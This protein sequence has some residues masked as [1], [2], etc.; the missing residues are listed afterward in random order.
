MIYRCP[1]CKQEVSKQL[2]E[3]ITGIWEAKDKL[4]RQLK[5]KEEKLKKSFEKQKKTITYNAQKKY[6]L[7]LKKLEEERKIIE[8]KYTN[9]LTK[10][11]ERIKKN[12]KHKFEQLKN[13]LRKKFQFDLKNKVKNKREELKRKEELMKNRYLQLNKQFISMQKRNKEEIEK[14]D[15]KIQSLQE[16]LNKGQT[17][18]VLGL[19]EEARF[20]K[21]LKDAYPN[22]KIVHHGKKGDI[23]HFIIDKGKEV[24]LIVYEL[25]KVTSGFKK[26]H[27]KQTY[28]AKQQR[29]ADYGI[30]V[31]NAKPPRGETFG[32]FVKN[33]IIIIHPA[34]VLALIDILRSH[35]ITISRLKLSKEKRNKL[36]A[37]V[38]DYIQS[39]EFKNNIIGII[40]DT[41]QVY[42]LLK[43]EIKSHMKNWKS[44]FEKYSEI[45]K[46]A[47]SIKDKAIEL[48]LENKERKLLPEKIKFLKP[49]EL[50]NKIE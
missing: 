20:V 38:L 12:E 2:Y 25:K 50:P 43:D 23:S 31:T 19:L 4:L 40:E 26:D 49:I 8:D 30:L 36:I 1:L 41:I 45:N 13:E 37:N 6:N 39:R 44:R 24:G 34:G 10:V 47:E 22:D 5:E 28:D 11:V 9:K 18:Q 14:K 29:K 17:P 42:E 7:L 3:K 27:L 32:F 21:E 46:K 35:V 16:Q 15:K 33:D 48:L